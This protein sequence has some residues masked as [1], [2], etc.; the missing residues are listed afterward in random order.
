MRAVTRRVRATG[1]KQA[2]PP[3]GRFTIDDYRALLEAALAEDRPVL[4]Y[5]GGALRFVWVPDG[6]RLWDADALGCAEVREEDGAPAVVW[7]G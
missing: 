2:M 4:V 7:R 5:Q 1:L 6:H 3:P